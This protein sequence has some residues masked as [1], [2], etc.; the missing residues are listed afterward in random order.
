MKESL[1][2]RPANKGLSTRHVFWMLSVGVLLL[3]IAI[4]LL[5]A[6]LLKQNNRTA[7]T[8]LATLP[9]SPPADAAP[10]AQFPSRNRPDLA[11]Q[12]PGVPTNTTLVI[13]N[14]EHSSVTQIVPVPVP[15][16]A[17]GVPIP[18]AHTVKANPALTNYTEKIPG[19]TVTFDMVAI[20]GGAITIGSPVEEIGRDSN[21]LAQ[22]AVSVK[23]FWMGKCEVTWAEYIPFVFADT[24]ERQKSKADGI[25][26][27]TKPYGS[28][29]R[30]RGEKG[31]PAIGMSQLSATEF[32]KWLSWKTGKKYRLPTEAEWEYACR[33]GAETS[34]FWGASAGQAKEYGW[35]AN[36][37]QGTT[38]PCGKLK[39]NKFG[40]YDIVGN[41]AEWTQL[42]AKETPG[43]VRGGAFTSQAEGLRNAS[44]LIDNP[45]W[46]ESDP[47]S[48]PSIWWLSAADFVG[49]RVVRSAD[50]ETSLFGS[51]AK[52]TPTAP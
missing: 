2:D 3:G 29:Y 9:S 41:V 33:A 19:T 5:I 11:P 36:N 43:V 23:S 13:A 37:S 1:P 15:G 17:V 52:A 44:R 40:L 31:F 18:S 28:I 12:A 45:S 42:S 39:P 51:T 22:A 4:G 6:L 38:Q 47:Q 50:D 48:P 30:E 16:I 32:C 7:N 10:P 46:N 20:P 34:Y 35:F 25:T 26:S 8:N 49:I 24:A 14:S 21:D 27:P